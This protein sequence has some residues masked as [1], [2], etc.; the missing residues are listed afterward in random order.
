[1]KS[2]M[3]ST[4]GHTMVYLS[5]AA[6]PWSISAP[7]VAAPSQPPGSSAGPP[8]PGPAVSQ[9]QRLTD[10]PWPV[11]HRLAP[12]PTY[13]SIIR[14]T[15]P[16]RTHAHTHTHERARTHTDTNTD[17]RGPSWRCPSRASAPASRTPPPSS[18]AHPTPIA[19]ARACVLRPCDS[20]YKPEAGSS[21]HTL[22]K[23]DKTQRTH[24][25]VHRQARTQARTCARLLSAFVR[26]ANTQ[27][28]TR[29]HDHVHDDPLKARRGARAGA[30]P[31]F[32]PGAARV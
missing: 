9:R 17:T 26:K 8:L 28:D 31:C 27:A 32:S 30:G 11:T 29:A 15:K 10:I 22:R 1:M 4:C 6:I 23:V 20:V 16:T 5:T 2:S 25:R 21:R 3:P 12:A 18:S 13:S 19:H 24:A 14:H 7:L